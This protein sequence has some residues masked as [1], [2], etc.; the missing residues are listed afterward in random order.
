MVSDWIHC[1]ACW[2]QP[3]QG[4]V[5]FFTSC[6][7]IICQ[8]CTLSNGTPDGQQ[9][10]SCSHCN[11]KCAL[12]EIN[13]NLRPE[14]QVLFRNP[15]ELATQYMKTL[16]QVL[17]FQASNRARLSSHI[18]E[19]EKKY[20]KY[21]LLA[22]EEI[23]RRI[24]LENKAVKE[25]MRLKCELDMERMRC[26]DLE[27]KVAEQEKQIEEL[28]KGSPAIARSDSGIDNEMET[29][30]GLSFLN[31]ATSTPIRNCSP[32]NR[33]TSTGHRN[34]NHISDVFASAAQNMP[35][36]ITFSTSNIMT[37]PAMLGLKKGK[38][39]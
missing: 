34:H 21:N 25:H 38:H 10:A 12:I 29:D 13:R 1:N 35:S 7:H 26:R 30:S 5:Y 11:K 2:R 3:A 15:K 6:G 16:S 18:S 33:F 28:R 32:N 22:K 39:G 8:K 23:K 17:E 36:P 27:A 4:V 14:L 31:V 20:I 37:T 24:E 19:R 9:S